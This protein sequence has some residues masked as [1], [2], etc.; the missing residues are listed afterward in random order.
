MIDTVVKKQLKSYAD[1]LRHTR[2]HY[3]RT[4]DL[5]IAK[6]PKRNKFTIR[7]SALQ[8][9]ELKRLNAN[10]VGKLR[11]DKL[12]TRNSSHFKKPVVKAED[13]NVDAHWVDDD[14]ERKR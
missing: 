5:V 13:V 14:Q 1:S 6:H 3:L 8:G 11:V 7:S 12:L 9:S 4:G 2:H 10:G